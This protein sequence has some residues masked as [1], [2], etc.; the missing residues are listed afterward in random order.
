M[1]IPFWALRH[2]GPTI[3]AILKVV[4]AG[5]SPALETPGPLLSETVPA[6]HPKL[7]AA[8]KSWCNDATPEQQTPDHFF[9]QWGFPLL[10][11][12]LGGSPYPMSKI[13][14]Q[15]FAMSRNAP[16]PAGQPLTVSAQLMAVDEVPGKA[17]LHTRVVTG[18]EGQPEA[19]NC[20]IFS[21]V[22]LPKTKVRGERAARPEDN[23]TWRAI[24]TFR[25]GRFEGAKY[26]C[27]SG[28]INPLHWFPPFAW[29]AGMKAP[30]LHGFAAGSLVTASLD[31]QPDQTGGRV[32]ALDMRF[33]R[34][35][36]LPAQ[37]TLELAED[38]SGQHLRVI[39]GKGKPC[40]VGTFRAAS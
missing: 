37:L 10:G 33:I 34:P 18:Y 30:I 27:L 20:D 9:P 26:S 32:S 6:R 15:G 16:L 11:E 24:E 28:D 38:P 17:K 4:F 12:A 36:V 14:N 31:R 23:K 19:L 5:K 2:Q 21:V 22:P 35:M 39:D 1:S 3:R 13:L 40:V 7:L 25:A 8:F 29:A